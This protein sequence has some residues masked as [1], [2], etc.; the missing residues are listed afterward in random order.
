MVSRNLWPR[1]VLA[2]LAGAGLLL[3]SALGVAAAGP[4]EPAA[5]PSATLPVGSSVQQGP[6]PDLVILYA[7][8]VMGWTE[9]CG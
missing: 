4:G 7:G 9:P 5:P 6:I 1:G 8:E 2:I 3:A